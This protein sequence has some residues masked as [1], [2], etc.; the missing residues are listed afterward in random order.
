MVWI[1]DYERLFGALNEMVTGKSH[2]L[3][4]AVLTHALGEV[5]DQSNARDGCFLAVIERLTARARWGT[6][7]RTPLLWDGKRGLLDY[8]KWQESRVRS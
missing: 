8:R 6:I 3:A 4:L 7:E 1:D 5:I 2:N